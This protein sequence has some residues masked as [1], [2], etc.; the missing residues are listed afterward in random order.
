[1]LEK[2]GED[3][4]EQLSLYSQNEDIQKKEN[5]TKCFDKLESKFGKNIV[6][7]GFTKHKEK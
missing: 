7:T 6:Q 2:I 5:L 3:G 4:V 1:V